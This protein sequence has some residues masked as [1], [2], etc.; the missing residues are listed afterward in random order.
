MMDGLELNID[1]VWKN[2]LGKL[3]IRIE[4]TPYHKSTGNTWRPVGQRSTSLPRGP[5]ETYGDMVKAK[6]GTPYRKSTGERSTPVETYR[7][8]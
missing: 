4:G 5:V 3:L 6:G 2:W 1:G 8:I 7:E